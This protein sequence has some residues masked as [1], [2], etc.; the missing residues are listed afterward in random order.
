MS[1]NKSSS[2][3]ENYLP[4]G[5]NFGEGRPSSVPTPTM[6]NYNQD[7]TPSQ[8]FKYYIEGINSDHKE[9]HKYNISSYKT[10]QCMQ[11]LFELNEEFQKQVKILT[12][13]VESLE[14]SI[15]DANNELNDTD[16]VF[17]QRMDISK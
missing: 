4:G 13:K 2:I 8:R 9:G 3:I 10:S 1:E 11:S 7:W 5:P 6:Y 14:T 17:V 16:T 15:Q 12:E